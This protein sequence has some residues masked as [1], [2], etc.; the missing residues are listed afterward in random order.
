MAELL[1]FNPTTSTKCKFDEDVDIH[2]YTLDQLQA[3]STNQTSVYNCNGEESSRNNGSYD[4]N[5]DN[6][7]NE[8]GANKLAE[9]EQ[10][11]GGGWDSGLDSYT[12]E[13]V[14]L[15]GRCFKKLV[16]LGPGQSVQDRIIDMKARNTSCGAFSV[17][18]YNP[19]KLM[20]GQFELL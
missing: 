1:V 9:N 2:N 15:K 17:I 5:E 11:A 13:L 8:N 14:P 19:K 20:E 7:E 6:I 16:Q 3:Y 10:E 18:L 12:E 4:E